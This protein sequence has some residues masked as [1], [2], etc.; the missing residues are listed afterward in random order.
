MLVAHSHDQSALSSGDIEARHCTGEGH[1][2]QASLLLE[3]F[4]FLSRSMMRKAALDHSHTEH[5]G[6]LES[7]GEVGRESV[8]APSARS[9]SGNSSACPDKLARSMNAWSRSMG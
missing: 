7:L 5:H 1:A 2:H 3:V 4:F 9:S 8:T 6:E